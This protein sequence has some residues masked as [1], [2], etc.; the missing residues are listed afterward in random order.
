MFEENINNIY[1]Y[2][3]HF[4]GNFLKVMELISWWI[5]VCRILGTLTLQNT[6]LG[7]AGGSKK[8][9]KRSQTPLVHPLV[10]TPINTWLLPVSRSDAC[11]IRWQDKQEHESVNIMLSCNLPL[12]DFEWDS[13]RGPW[14]SAWHLPPAAQPAALW[15]KCWQRSSRWRGWGGKRPELR[16]RRSANVLFFYKTHQ[17]CMCTRRNSGLNIYS[18]ALYNIFGMVYSLVSWKGRWAAVKPVLL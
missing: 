5:C 2:I 8:P 6:W 9:Q 16:T 4:L 10:S 3:Y 12:Q 13:L 17:P 7:K 18:M 15:R 14:G 11:W 1:I